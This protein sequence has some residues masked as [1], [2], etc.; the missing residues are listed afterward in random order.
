LPQVGNVWIHVSPISPNH[1]SKFFIPRVE[2]LFRT[3]DRILR[4]ENFGA[5]SWLISWKTFDDDNF[6]I[7]WQMDSTNEPTFI[8]LPF[9]VMI[10]DPLLQGRQSNFLLWPRIDNLAL[11]NYTHLLDSSIKLWSMLWAT[12]T[13]L[14]S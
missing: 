10:L 11:K 1:F 13:I 9:S 14:R 2:D 6:G 3:R 12:I 7:W 4:V 8:L 5:R